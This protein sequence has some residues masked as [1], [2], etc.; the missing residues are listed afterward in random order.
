[1]TDEIKLK[2]TSG[3]SLSEK[4]AEIYL[5][6]IANEVRNGQGIVDPE[7]SDC[8]K[9]FECSRD[10]GLTVSP[11]YKVQLINI[12]EQLNLPITHYSTAV[13]L[14]VNNK[15]KSYLVD[16]T[17]AQ[18]FKEE[19]VLDNLEIGHINRK[20]E[21]LEKKYFEGQLIVKGYVELNEENIRFYLDNF[22]EL[23][24]IEHNIVRNSRYDDFV[25]YLKKKEVQLNKVNKSLELKERKEL[26][27]NFRNDIIE[28]IKLKQSGEGELE[29]ETGKTL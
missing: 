29:Q 2:V 15:P 5:D 24:K 4:E 3:D 13:V 6:F 11:K 16:L 9:C 18:F 20:N 21:S 1:M 7:D 23:C 10:T 25:R 27:T 28:I 19:F 26:L 22:F 8:T 14:N 12:K 17:Y